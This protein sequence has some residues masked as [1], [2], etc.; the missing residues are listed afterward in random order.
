[1]MALYSYFRSSTSYRARIALNIKDVDY[2]L[3]P[4]N[5][6][7]GEQREASYLALNPLGGVPVLKDGDYTLG[8]SLAIIEYLDARIPEPRLIPDDIRDAGI[9]RQI[10][11]SI[12]EDIHPLINM[13]T[14]KYLSDNLG[15]DDAAKAAW[16]R[17]WMETGMAAVEAIL[18]RSARAGNFAMGGRVSM[19]DI[20]IVPQMYS[21]R[22]FGVDVTPYKLC[23]R[24]EAHC[25]TLPEFWH[26]APEH[27]PDAPLDLAP[28]HGQNSPLLKNAA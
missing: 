28:I 18:E 11:A 2:D 8:Q 26:A 19:A 24:I 1:M 14:Q 7:K 27:Q 10:A 5:I 13:K 22:R 21:M 25:I 12:A 9:V 16:A 6:L 15:A 3:I 17:H 20:F 4:V 23:R